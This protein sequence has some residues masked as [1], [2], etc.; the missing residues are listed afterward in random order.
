LNDTLCEGCNTCDFPWNVTIEYCYTMRKCFDECFSS[1]FSQNSNSYISIVN[2][3]IFVDELVVE[4][5]WVSLTNTI[6]S[7]QGNISFNGKSI[8]LFDG[9]S[10]I[11]TT[12]CIF[13]N[14][15]TLIKYGSNITNDPNIEIL[16]F[17]FGCIQG[18]QNIIID[19]YCSDIIKN[20]LPTLAV[21]SNHIGI[22]FQNCWDTASF[23]LYYVFFSVLYLALIMTMAWIIH[24]YWLSKKAIPTEDVKINE[25][26]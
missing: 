3:V 5:K 11:N 18:T 14:S 23:Q 4:T 25:L 26:G 7:S 9:E 13:F 15:S 1:L 19:S 24:K 2:D 22:T 10:Y 8:I 12:Q 20:K 21:S 17:E 16:L 6:I